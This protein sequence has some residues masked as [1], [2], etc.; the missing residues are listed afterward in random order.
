MTDANNNISG[1]WLP[2]SGQ[3]GGTITVLALSPG[4]PSDQ[5]VFA[6][7]HAG[8]FR[9]TDGGRAWEPWGDGITSPFIE[10]VGISP[11]F[12]KDRT[13]MAGS[14]DG[15][16]FKSTDGGQ[17]WS[18]LGWIGEHSP[19]IALAF[20]PNYAED[21]NVF[22]GT[23]SDGIYRSTDRGA[24]WASSNF[25][26]L[27]ICTMAIGVSPDYALDETIWLATA[28]GLYRSRNGGR[29]WREVVVM[30]GDSFAV[31]ALAVARGG[32]PAPVIFI[33]TEEKGMLRS[34]DGGVTWQETNQGFSDLCINAIATSPRF[35]ED[36]MA[37]AATSDGLFT[38]VDSGDNWKP[39]ESGPESGL[40]VAIGATL[41]GSLALLAGQ[42]YGG[43][44]RSED[45]G[46]TWETATGLIAESLL[47]M[48]VSP[49][50]GADHTIF[51]WG[52]DEGVRR[53]ADGG[54]TW[55][56]ADSGLDPV[57]TTSVMFSPSYGQDKLL[58]ATTSNGVYRTDNGG[59]LWETSVLY[60]LS[61]SMVAAA[62][63]F[64]KD[65]L[66]LAV[67]AGHLFGSLS[68]GKGWQRVENDFEM[69][70][71]AWVGFSTNFASDQAF[72]VATRQTER[73]Q[74][75]GL[76]R[77]WKGV[78]R[79]GTPEREPGERWKPKW[80][81]VFAQR[82]S[83][84]LVACVMPPTM[85][86]DNAF[87][88]AVGGHVYRQLPGS[89][90]KVGDEI[91]PI[92]TSAAMGNRNPSVVGVSL[93]PDFAR[94]RIMFAATSDGVYKSKDAGVS[95]QAI[96]EGLDRRAVISV[97]ASPAYGKDRTVFALT[98]GGQLW[99][100]RDG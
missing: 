73:G 54:V 34:T 52:I 80:E 18:C 39:V 97:A 76:V 40:A 7:T 95:W 44:A 26:L 53:S 87:F 99:R 78:A 98:L 77:V 74:V 84:N 63:S 4:F 94:D 49:N 22:A 1:R 15:V 30:K 83:G 51:T 27:E 42:A 28:S 5:T 90:E 75:A 9:S 56:Q 86:Q 10:A 48:A 69:D 43:I 23:F 37:L 79:A 58:F 17:N 89:R 91:R 55:E 59:D 71:I 20:S 85:R 68:G 50:F 21:G 60:N 8:L 81:C 33:G 96:S 11:N 6:G 32:S 2:I 19:V 64:A 65:G 25:G 13:M 36:H 31:Q 45:D 93:S 46:S 41:G 57:E 72:Y 88:V 100:L 24:T 35:A 14:R 70:D 16:L 92:W 47:G 66:M 61:V 62:P 38:S 67:G 3:E 29:S 12:A 82:E